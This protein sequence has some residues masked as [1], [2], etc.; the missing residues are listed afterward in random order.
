[1][2]AYTSTAYAA[3][4]ATGG[5]VIDIEKARLRRQ[6]MDRANRLSDRERAVLG[7]LAQGHATEDIAGS[8]FLSPHTVR[9]H[10]KAAMRKLD[11]RTRAHA[12]AIALTAGT[13]DA[14]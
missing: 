5:Q 6:L 7:E 10:V 4:Y 12:V 3:G 9:S 1:M 8:L 2:N 11:A 14:I 13:I